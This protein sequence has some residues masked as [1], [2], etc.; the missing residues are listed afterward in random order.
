MIRRLVTSAAV[1]LAGLVSLTACSSEPVPV[2]P[3]ITYTHLPP[4]E[5]NV[6][7]IDIVNQF[8]PT[9]REP[10][11]EHMM[12]VPQDQA[13]VDWARDRFKAAGDNGYLAR[14]YIV[15]APVVE[16]QL[17]VKEGFSGMFSKEPA[18]RYNAHLEVRIEIRDDF[19]RVLGEA[20]ATV[21]RQREVLEDISLADREQAWFLM[22][23]SQIRDLNRRMEQEI[24]RYLRDHLATP[25]VFTPAGQ[26]APPY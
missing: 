12:P 13:A 20:T 1:A 26:T 14:I 5:L 17:P 8:Q 9:F 25:I 19:R 21:D 16:T 7:S 2:F 22:V 18:Q 11:V 3:E 15:D 6:S 10:H 4:I 24:D 23:E